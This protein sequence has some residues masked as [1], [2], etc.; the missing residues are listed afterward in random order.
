M[1][2]GLTFLGLLLLVL[3]EQA[4]RRWRRGAR[5]DWM[6]LAANL[7]SGHM[8]LWLFRTGEIAVYGVVLDHASLHWLAAWPTGLQWAF[9]LVAWDR[10]FWTMH[11]AHHH[12]PLLWKIHAVHHEG[13]EMSLSLA[14]R[15]GWYSSLSD[16]PFM[17]PLAIIGLPLP[18]F[19]AVSSIHYAVQFWNHVSPDLVG[20][21]GPL[22]RWLVTPTVHRVHHGLQ[23]VYHNRNFG[24]TLL[25]WDRLFGTYQ[26][27]LPELP[28]LYGL[29]DQAPVNNPLAMNHRAL[30]RDVSARPACAPGWYLG[31]GAVLLFC[32]TAYAIERGAQPGQVT[33]A[34]GL[35]AASVGLGMAAD[36]RRSGMLV[37]LATTLGL[38]GWAAVYASVPALALT[39]VL[40][41]H[42]LGGLWFGRLA[43][44]TRIQRRL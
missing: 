7:N 26:P 1:G 38:T 24:S 37:W 35:I 11:A 17:L 41:V 32:L 27:E 16:L 25:F 29:A 31:S 23:S 20:R 10:C 8:L 14:I 40:A 4:W 42:A 33:L 34:A 21:L 2:Y 28:R 39:S 18:I 6:N 22:D 13:T 3:A 5:I 44:R 36:G 9:G 30:F 12:V 19:L 43:G 15:N